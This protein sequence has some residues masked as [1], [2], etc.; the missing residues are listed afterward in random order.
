MTLVHRAAGRTTVA[1]AVVVEAAKVVRVVTVV[2][3]S[4]VAVV[5]TSTSSSVVTVVVVASVIGS[6]WTNVVVDTSVIVKVTTA[7][8]TE[9]AEGVGSDKH[10][11]ALERADEA[12]MRRRSGMATTARSS[13]SGAAA[14]RLAARI[15]VVKLVHVVVLAGGVIVEMSV[16]V[17]G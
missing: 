13:T 15:S 9:V 7:T 16:D 10:K 12:K 8:E 1:D 2:T 17:T 11:H 3:D 6:T 4:V 14:D 5:G